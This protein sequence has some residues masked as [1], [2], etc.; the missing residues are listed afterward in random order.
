MNYNKPYLRD[1][2]NLSKNNAFNYHPRT[3][4]HSIGKNFVF[5]STHMNKMVKKVV[6]KDEI[7]T[8]K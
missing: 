1:S 5:A 8:S 6:R 7:S 2:S 4:K 3:A